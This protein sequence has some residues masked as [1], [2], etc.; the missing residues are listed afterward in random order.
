MIREKATSPVLGCGF[1]F[2]KS[3]YEGDPHMRFSASP[4]PKSKAPLFNGARVLPSHLAWR[5]S[6]SESPDSEAQLT[7]MEVRYA[8]TANNQQKDGCSHGS[9][10]FGP[11][12]N[13]ERSLRPWHPGEQ[14]VDESIQRGHSNYTAS[15]V[16]SLLSSK[17]LPVTLATRFG[18]RRSYWSRW[19]NFAG[20]RL[21]PC[22]GHGCCTRCGEGKCR[23]NSSA[24]YLQWQGTI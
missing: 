12:P 19:A 13:K 10:A 4:I 18:G 3:F 11:S 24:W 23:M 17:K 5:S 14:A 22:S 9:M 2:F 20:Q 8:V 1:S 15:S 16:P 7:A 6:G 21:W